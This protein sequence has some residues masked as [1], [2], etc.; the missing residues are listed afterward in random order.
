M[1]ALA[2]VAMIAVFGA[3]LAG[4]GDDDSDGGEVAAEEQATG[5][6]AEDPSGSAGQEQN[7]A[8]DRN[9]PGEQVEARDSEFGTI[10]VDSGDRTLYLFDKESSDASQCYGACAAAWP[11]FVTEGDPQAGKG[12]DRELL[13]TTK[14]DDGT[15]QVT[16]NG[17]PLY[18]YVDDPVGEVLCHNVEEFGGLWLVVTP[19]GNAAT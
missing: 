4:C 19:D 3:A 12:V 14:R 8:R 9:R 11:P 10:L 13:G 6:A 15:T 1:R 18:F 16:Y 7:A 17:N 2:A 5:A